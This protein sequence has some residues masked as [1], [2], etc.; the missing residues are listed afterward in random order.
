M[1]NGQ[2]AHDAVQDAVRVLNR[3]VRRWSRSDRKR[4]N[5]AV[6]AAAEAHQG[7][8]RA[9]G[10]PYVCHPILVA[11]IVAESGGDLPTVIGALLHD[12]VED[13]NMT[14]QDVQ[15][16]FGDDVR[17]IVDGCTKVAGVRVNGEDALEAARM[18]KLLVALAHDPRVL[19]VKSADRLHNMRT[20]EHL[21]EN[22]R[23]RIG[24]ETLALYGP[25][26]GRVGLTHIK[27][28]LEDRAFAAADP[29]AYAAVRDQ[30]QTPEMHDQLGHAL[31]RLSAH[32]R[33]EGVNGSAQ[34]RIKMPWSAY[35]KAQ[36]LGIPVKDLHDLI[37]LRVIVPTVRDC[38][39]ALGVVHTLWGPAEGR[40]KDYV[41]RPKFNRYQSLHT[42]V[43]GDSGTLIEIQIRTPQMHAEAEHGQAAHRTYKNAEPD[44]PAWLR[45]LLDDHGEDDHEYLK[46]VH[47]ELSAEEEILVLTP[48]GD[49]HVLPG[50]ATV[51]DFAY[52]VHTAI[53]DTCTAAE[54]N[55]I[56]TPATAALQTG[57]RVRILVGRD[58]APP[59]EWV[60]FAATR[61]ART[62]IK[63]AR[64]KHEAQARQSAEQPTMELPVLGSGGSA[65]NA[66]NPERSLLEVLAENRPGLLGD[67]ARTIAETGG[68]ILFSSATVLPDGIGRDLFDIVHP[69]VSLERL[70]DA[71]TGVQGVRSV[72][73][74]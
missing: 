2:E 70:M 30:L 65:A 37:G 6:R 44:E 7:Q 61:K 23:Q 50:G 54:V 32:L 63:N 31:T 46:A 13:T 53:G 22:K 43:V 55:G 51:I 21:P 29:A 14:L 41:A 71:L 20:I 45:R 59:E 1:H 33:S 73:V 69:E 25:L 3:A 60:T 5:E 64:R 74:L 15:N 10:E 52:T 27:A 24:R 38:Y 17:G 9:S 26:A 57:D 58:G 11:S 36:S 49:A 40:F 47:R 4:V 8:F 66:P 19:V 12:T 62:A 39:V 42:S 56:L 48:D 68:D 16:Q 67:L 34:G 18:R 35:R 28:E 72:N